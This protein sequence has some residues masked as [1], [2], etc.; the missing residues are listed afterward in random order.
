M[1]DLQ[2][3]WNQKTLSFSKIAGPLAE[4][5]RQCA[6]ELYLYMSTTVAV[7]GQVDEHGED[8]FR[9]EVLADGF[10]HLEAFHECARGIMARFPMGEASDY[11]ENLAFFT[12]E[13]LE[14]VVR[15]MLL[16]WRA[17][18]EFWW[19]ENKSNGSPFVLQSN[20]PRLDE[21]LGDWIA[22]RRFCR[23]TMTALA[24]AYEFR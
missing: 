5:D 4:Q 6:W 7:R 19:D 21:M 23:E 2:I 1:P 16:K 8:H 14:S 13:F 22:L 9:G 10:S 11:P 17:E 12:A 3:P 18:Y 20:Y 15:P 24:R